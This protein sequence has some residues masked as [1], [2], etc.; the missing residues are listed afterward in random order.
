[1]PTYLYIPE[2]Q[3][4]TDVATQGSNS[5][6]I[7]DVWVYTNDNLQGIYQL[8][9]HIPVIAEG[10]TKL[11]F[12]GGIFINGISD[13]R[14]EYPNYADAVIQADLVPAE[15]DTFIPVVEYKTATRFL[16]IEDFENGN[17]FVNLTRDIEGP[18]VFEGK[19]SGRIS[20]DS[21]RRIEVRTTNYFNIPS[22]TGVVFVELDYKSS[23]VM[24]AGVALQTPQGNITATKV[25]IS[26]QSNWNKIYINFTPEVARTQASAI[27][28]YFVV[29]AT[30][31]TAPVDIL[32]DNVKILFL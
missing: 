19:V 14:V 26:P 13:T 16:L 10:P 18:D 9:A 20:V 21:T 6:K 27:K 12:N 17:E 8:P 5:E 29:D 7:T 2:V 31:D 23:H 4:K 1:M 22:Y 11:S 15:T 30:G 24:T 32:V 3:V 25:N 28:L